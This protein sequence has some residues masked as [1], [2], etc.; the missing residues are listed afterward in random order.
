MD[1]EWVDL[2]FSDGAEGVSFHHGDFVTELRRSM[3]K[4]NELPEVKK[5]GG[6]V[7]VIE[8]VADG[9]VF[10]SRD[11]NLVRGVTYRPRCVPAAGAANSS[12]TSGAGLIEY[13]K[14]RIRRTKST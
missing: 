12:T 10:D 2:P 7:T 14:E 13:S 1:G 3:L 4:A 11:T 6:R 8:G 5:S 9:F